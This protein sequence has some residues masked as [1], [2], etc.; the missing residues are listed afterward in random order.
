MHHPHY[1]LLLIS[2]YFWEVICPLKCRWIILLNSYLFNLN[3]F[4][5]IFSKHFSVMSS[6]I[7][8][9]Q[10]QMIYVFSART[11]VHF[12]FRYKWRVNRTNFVL[13][14]KKHIH[15]RRSGLSFT[16]YRVTSCIHWSQQNFF[17]LILDETRLNAKSMMILFPWI[18]LL[19]ETKTSLEVYAQQKG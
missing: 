5:Q 4:W 14:Q 1:I 9:S 17:P 15:D 2:T 3:T 11:M 19:S 16:N 13:S 10:H 18:T 7:Q 12:V 6:S 8:H